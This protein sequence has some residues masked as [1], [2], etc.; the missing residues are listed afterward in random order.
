M[1]SAGRSRR[2]SMVPINQSF[3]QLEKNYGKDNFLLFLTAD[4][5]AAYP[6]SELLSHK[7]NAGYFNTRILADSIKHT[8]IRLYNDSSI[9][10]C[11]MN[12]EVYLNHNLIDRKKLSL[13]N[14]QDEIVTRILSFKGVSNA[15]TSY[16]LNGEELKNKAGSLIQNGFYLQRSGDIAFL[17]EP[18]WLDDYS[19]TGTSHGSAYTYDTHVPLIWY[20]WEIKAGYTSEPIDISDIA[21][22]IASLLN[23]MAPSACTG[24]PIRAICK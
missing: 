24:K 4:H 1:F 9:F 11:I 2:I 5:A 17:L 12:N 14:I 16:Q 19:R 10:S 3:A 8:L 22:S 6:P 23:I 13:K 20:G 18:A 21:P 15:Y 7:M